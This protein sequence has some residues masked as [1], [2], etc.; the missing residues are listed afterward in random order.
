MVLKAFSMAG[1]APAEPSY[2]TRVMPTQVEGETHDHADVFESGL[3]LQQGTLLRDGRRVERPPSCRIGLAGWLDSSSG[4]AAQN[5]ALQWLQDAVDAE[6]AQAVRRLRGDFVL[7]HVAA[8]GEALRIYR[9]LT[10]SVPL[11]WTSTVTSVSWSTDPYA[12]LPDGRANLRDISVDLLPFILAEMAFPD[13]RSWFTDIQRLP[14]GSCLE[15]LQGRPPAVRPFDGYVIGMERPKTVAEAAEGLRALLGQACRRAFRGERASVLLSGGLDSSTVAIEA[16]RAASSAVGLH[17]TL[18]DFPRYG[19]DLADAQAVGR[20]CGMW[21]DTYDMFSSLGSEGRYLNGG[22][23]GSLPQ[24][25]VPQSGPAVAVDHAIRN[26]ATIVASGVGA[27]QLF[28]LDQRWGMYGVMGM[29]LFNPLVSGDSPWRQ[30]TEMLQSGS[31][32]HEDGESVAVR[33][34]RFIHSR[35]TNQPTA[36]LP[37]T[38]VAVRRTGLS[39]DAS[40]ALQSGIERM[41][42]DFIGRSSS[43]ALSGG[44]R[45]FATRGFEYGLTAKLYV[46]A[47]L[48][49][50]NLH[51]GW[52]NWYRRNGIISFSPFADRD[53]VEYAI[54]LH[55]RHRTAMAHG[56]TLDK[57]ALRFA[58]HSELP[59]GIA[60]R[61]AQSRYDAI[62]SVF[63]TTNYDACKSMLTDDSRLRELGITDPKFCEQLSRDDVYQ[64][65]EE[66][67]RLCV[68]E[69]WLRSLDDH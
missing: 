31:D 32:P 65:G 6:G 42:A 10:S 37:A 3:K 33:T 62:S 63:V 22:A 50:L 25:H 20:S 30:M 7:A 35:V 55:P 49:A 46:N 28:A 36:I 48:N 44:E 18:G 64:I 24:T 51:A 39:A 19:D 45:P 59:A 53:V 1:T 16:S 69:Q 41:A 4:P 11:F 58:Y 43:V 47:S 56:T 21:V 38:N 9:G 67:A 61:T 34:A 60:R 26:G 5:A 40:Q 8:E 57:F 13:T 2:H 15:I 23:A 66:V 27:D 12:L 68:L 17:F 52:L 54:G 29:R 14:P